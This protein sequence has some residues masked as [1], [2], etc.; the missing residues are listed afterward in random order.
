MSEYVKGVFALA[1]LLML[2]LYLVP[3]ERFKRYIRFFTEIVLTVGVLSPVLSMICDND[4][5][6]EL[7]AYE[8]FTENL[9]EIARDMERMEYL[10]NDYYLEE[11]ERAIAEDVKGIALGIAETYGYTVEDV[12]VHLTKEYRLDA[13]NLSLAKADAE[14][15][16]NTIVIERIQIGEQMHTED[17]GEEEKGM[18]AEIRHKLAEYYQMDESLIEIQK[19]VSG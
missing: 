14:E 13:M 15:R 1:I 19:Q 12:E 5:F 3:G 16:E 17:V 10:Q 9:S 7:I 8:T 4:R 11:Y 6:L 2:L 18:T